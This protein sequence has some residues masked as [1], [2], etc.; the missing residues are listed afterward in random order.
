M[1]RVNKNRI[2]VDHDDEPVFTELDWKIL[3]AQMEMLHAFWDARLKLSYKE[4]ET[5]PP[6]SRRSSSSGRT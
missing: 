1:M 3:Y 4:R 5:L 6:A 2:R